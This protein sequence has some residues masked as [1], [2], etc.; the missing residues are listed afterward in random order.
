MFVRESVNNIYTLQFEVSD[1]GIGIRPEQAAKLFRM[2]EQAD[3]STSRNFGGTGL[4]LALSKRI[5]EIMGG[6]IRVESEAD[7]GSTFCL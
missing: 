7:K 2:F 3:S 1:T 6:E 5:V 4:G